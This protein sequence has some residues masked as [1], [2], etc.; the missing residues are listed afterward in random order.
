LLW[1]IGV[2]A[3]LFAMILFDDSANPD[4]QA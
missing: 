4:S 1:L 3:Y 2:S